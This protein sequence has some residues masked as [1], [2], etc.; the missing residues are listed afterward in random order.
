MHI[1]VKNVGAGKYKEGNG[2]ILHDMWE[3]DSTD[4]VFTSDQQRSSEL[5]VPSR[6]MECLFNA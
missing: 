6:N 1:W 3:L 5:F 4:K 2:S